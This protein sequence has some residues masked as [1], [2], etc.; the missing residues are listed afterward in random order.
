MAS[1]KRIGFFWGDEKITVVD[2]EK[3]APVQVVSS[4]LGSKTS[5][6]SPFSSNLTEEIQITVI[7]KKLLTDS[8]I[9]GGTFYV[10]LPMKEIILRSFVIPFVKSEDIQTAIKFEAKKYIPFDIQ[11]LSFV[12]HTI[13]FSEGQVK[14]LQVIFFAARKEVLAR[15]ERIFKQVNA[16]ITYCEPYI[17]SLSKSLLFRKEISPSEHIAFLILDQNLGRIC[18]IDKGIPQFIREFPVNAIAQPEETE[19]SAGALNLKIV[20][21]VLN[22]FDF[23]AR[24]FNGDRIE[25]I[26]VSSDF[27]QKDLI[28]S[29]ETELKV[30]IKRFTPNVTTAALNQ[31]SD[32]DAIYAMGACVVPPM[33][34]LSKFNFIGDKS[35]KAAFDNEIVSI[36]R[37]YKDIIITLFMCLVFLIAVYAFFQM[38]LKL[39]QD[40]L[41]RV[42]A[43]EGANLSLGKDDI[44]ADA[45]QYTDKLTQYKSV[46]TKSDLAIIFLKL[47]SHI[48]KGTLISDLSM[49][50]NSDDSGHVSINLKGEVLLED[51]N[52]QIAVVNQVYT[53]LKDD[54]DLAN[55]FTSVN[56]VSFNPETYNGQQV[57]GFNIHCS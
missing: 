23:Y 43:E 55:Y 29:L 50:Y 49:S 39:G 18:F 11:D 24:Q 44:Q 21:E 13:P 19:D 28:T 51:P 35:P 26:L 25:Q 5:S 34:S 7:L 6:S 52:A 3:N 40:Q 48:P 38:Q 15:Y 30:K 42:T 47:A 56:L 12:F 22:S 9:S 41:K 32:M 27:V 45:Q 4:P 46:R 36:L 37:P 54:K 31:S 17:V 20:N 16:E 57:T 1:S 14:R 33:D 2:F 8:Q 10:S 53:D